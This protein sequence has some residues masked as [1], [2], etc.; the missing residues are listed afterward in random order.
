MARRGDYTLVE[1][2]RRVRG[3]P[4]PDVTVVDMRRELEAGNLSLIHI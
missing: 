1:M 2:P 3:L 4:L